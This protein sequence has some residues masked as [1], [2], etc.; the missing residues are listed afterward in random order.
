MNQNNCK[1]Q[2]YENCS[3]ELGK[4]FFSTHMPNTEEGYAKWEAYNYVIFRIVKQQLSS[5][6]TRSVCDIS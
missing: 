4:K 2:T 6:K 3:N 1:I 5:L